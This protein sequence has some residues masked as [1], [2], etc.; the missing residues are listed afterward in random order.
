M[1][2]QKL[3]ARND[4]ELERLLWTV[5]FISN[6]TAMSFELDKC[7]KATFRPGMLVDTKYIVLGDGNIIKRKCTNILK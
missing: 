3:F 7:T 5:N 2:D 4:G 1:D 6:Y